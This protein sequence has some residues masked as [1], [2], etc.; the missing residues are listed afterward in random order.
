M[1]NR[2]LG[3]VIAEIKPFFEENGFTE[4]GNEF[5]SENKLVAIE[6]NEPRQMFELKIADVT[7][8]GN[9]AEYKVIS[10]WLFDD[11]QNQKD[12]EAVGIDFTNTLRKELGIK[13]IRVAN[14][15]D[16]E[17]PSATKSGNMT[18]SGFTKKML[19]IFPPLK[20]EYKNHIAVY[21]NFLYLN[22]FGEYLI[23]SIKK[24]YLTGTSKQVKKFTE[25]LKE[26][27][28]KGDRE[29]VNAVV[30]ILAAA[31]YNDA[32]ATEKIKAALADDKHLFT[33]YQNFL[34][35]LAKNKKLLKVL[36]K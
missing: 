13:K 19:D 12:A 27:Y 36:V 28:V 33:S 3:N 4:V 31:S 30:A 25:V 2:Y 5:K 8:E 1:D 7:E 16:V 11:S 21:G 29:T 23:P 32:E 22:F 14:T 17:L 18:I 9:E 24:V 34:P 26:A 15:E 35:A 6:Y 20:A 10:S